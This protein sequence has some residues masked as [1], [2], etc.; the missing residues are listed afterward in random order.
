MHELGQ[1]VKSSEN[2]VPLALD[3]VPVQLRLRYETGRYPLAM[4]AAEVF[5]V[6]DLAQLSGRRLADKTDKDPGAILDQTDNFALRDQLA[7]LP[8]DHKLREI[9]HSMV[10][11]VIAPAFGGRIS[12]TTRPTFRV[13]LP[14]TP[15]ISAWHRD[16]DITG[17][18]DYVN[19]WV[20]LVNVVDEN[21]LWIE[22]D[23]GS[24]NH[25]PVIV[26]YGEVLI[27]DGG[28][29]S[30]GSVLND[31]ERARVSLDLRFA[32]RMPDGSA[33]PTEVLSARPPPPFQLA[34]PVAPPHPW[35][36]RK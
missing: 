12:Y 33:R 20:P 5:E 27:F 30:H 23:Y 17:R 24:G 25:R 7:T 26:A 22:D 11:Q 15:P 3:D 21:T 16:A 36:G 4:A 28:L 2:E 19:A 29:L 35:R 31:S 9:Y 13:H 34:R 1:P 8:L 18:I 32:P 6:D 10:L 14:G